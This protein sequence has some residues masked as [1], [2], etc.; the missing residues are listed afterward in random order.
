MLALRALSI[1][2]QAFRRNV[3]GELG[4]EVEGIKHVK[5]LLEVLRVFRVEQHP[6]LERFVV[7]LP[8]RDWR[9]CYVLRQAFL[10]GLVEDANA[11]VDTETGMLPRQKVPGEVLVQEF[12]VHQ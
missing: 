7:D 12:A 2:A 5:I 11:V 1:P 4:E 10:G 6:P 9:P 3:L 8:Q